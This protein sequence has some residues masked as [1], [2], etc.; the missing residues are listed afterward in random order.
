MSI[1]QFLLHYFFSTIQKI[2][3]S[4]PGPE[5]LIIVTKKTI[6]KR[7]SNTLIFNRLMSSH[8]YNSV[9]HFIVLISSARDIE[10]QHYN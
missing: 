4:E 10:G 5:W 2:K 3:L 8:Q 9:N 7:V 1:Y 6:V